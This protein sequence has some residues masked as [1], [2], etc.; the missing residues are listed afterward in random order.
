MQKL[1]LNMNDAGLAVLFPDLYVD[2]E[3]IN[4]GEPNLPFLKSA[5]K[6]AYEQNK[7]YTGDVQGIKLLDI[8]IEGQNPNYKVS[9]VFDTF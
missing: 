6:T 9:I 8:E 2:G 7:K 3:E 1:D 4:W 5:I